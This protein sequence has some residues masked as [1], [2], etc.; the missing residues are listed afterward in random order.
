MSM[1]AL[2]TAVLVAV[3]V[4]ADLPS[5]VSIATDADGRRIVAVSGLLGSQRDQD[6]L[7]RYLDHPRLAGHQEEAALDTLR[8][9]IRIV[10]DAEG[11]DLEQ[12]IARFARLSNVV[13]YWEELEARDRV[14]PF[15]V[16]DLYREITNHTF[17]GEWAGMQSC[18]LGPE[19]PG[20]L[21]LWFSSNMPVVEG[22]PVAECRIARTDSGGLA[23]TTAMVDTLPMGSKRDEGRPLAIEAG[24]RLPR[25]GTGVVS[26]GRITAHCAGESDYALRIYG[27]D[28]WIWQSAR[29]FPGKVGVACVDLDGDLA[30]EIVVV[31]E[32][33][34]K[35]TITVL[36]TGPGAD[37]I[38]ARLAPLGMN[39]L[40]VWAV[41]EIV[42]TAGLDWE[43]RLRQDDIPWLADVD[44][45]VSQ[46]RRW[47]VLAHG[48]MGGRGAE[49]PAY[50][51]IDS[52]G[53]AAWLLEGGRR[54][55]NPMVADDGTVVIFE[56]RDGRPAAIL[57]SASGELAGS[58]LGEMP[59]AD[60]AYGIIDADG[61]RL[62][63]SVRNERGGIVRCEER[64]LS[65]A[66][67]EAGLGSGR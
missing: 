30:D 18:R 66:E 64:R 27:G 51:L 9:E 13:P 50:C 44:G 35:A 57:R 61:L 25:Q 7:A 3:A 46:D 16:P 24:A 65:W 12:V 19:D 49:R 59:A 32:S 14:S 43:V 62:G 37:L 33:H 2:M 67:L 36:G 40:P 48:G 29:H 6:S 15:P 47:C 39:G 38:E 20:V 60:L 26:V 42:R 52:A 10:T 5:S 54:L 21:T 22:W 23:F 8:D 55:K 17:S 11:E 41:R 63:V 53:R 1:P 31:S 56:D 45:R 4:A 34:G 58:W 28:R